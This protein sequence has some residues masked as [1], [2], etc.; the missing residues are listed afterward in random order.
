MGLEDTGKSSLILRIVQKIVKK[1][2][3][4]SQNGCT[5]LTV[6]L[7]TITNRAPGTKRIAVVFRRGGTYRNEVYGWKQFVDKLA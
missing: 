5:D 4:D 7:K 2:L 3:S 6:H 1:Q